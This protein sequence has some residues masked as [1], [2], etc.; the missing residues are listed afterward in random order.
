MGSR[1]E[2]SGGAR[3]G[4]GGRRWGWVVRGSE[5]IMFDTGTVTVEL[6]LWCG[7]G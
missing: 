3:R 5:R 7:Y 1:E 2:V 4:L 6:W